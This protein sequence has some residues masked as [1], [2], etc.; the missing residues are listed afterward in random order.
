MRNQQKT[1]TQSQTTKFE[2]ACSSRDFPL[3]NVFVYSSTEFLSLSFAIRRLPFP[4]LPFPSLPFP[5]LPFFYPNMTDSQAIAQVAATGSY[6]PLLRLLLDHALPKVLVEVI[7]QYMGPV[8]PEKGPFLMRSGEYFK[9]QCWAGKPNVMR[10]GY[11]GQEWIAQSNTDVRQCIVK[12]LSRTFRT[13]AN[14]RDCLPTH[15]QTDEAQEYL[16]IQ[17][18]NRTLSLEDAMRIL[19]SVQHYAGFRFDEDLC[20]PRHKQEYKRRKCRIT[21][22]VHMPKRVK[23][24]VPVFALYQR[25]FVLPPPLEQPHAQR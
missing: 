17:I 16:Y 15:L 6:L 11:E 22:L 10:D 25:N 9:P 18:N 5:S 8:E 7:A 3:V 21:C 14:T 1:V 12:R 4:S 20:Y 2:R 23:S 19:W 13:V 24:H